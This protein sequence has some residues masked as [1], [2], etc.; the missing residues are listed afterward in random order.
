MKEKVVSRIRRHSFALLVMLL[1]M[2]MVPGTVSATI[3]GSHAF[4]WW[5][6][7][8][9]VQVTTSLTPPVPGASTLLLGLEEWHLDQAQTTQWY[10][11][12]AIS[13]LPTNPFNGAN[14]TA[15]TPGSV[16]MPVVGAEAFI[17]RISNL[18]YAS[19]DNFSFSVGGGVNGISGININDTWNALQTAL[20]VAGSQ[21]MFNL[22]WLD[23][24]P[25]D[26]GGVE[27]WDFNAFA[28]PGNFEW[29]ITPFQGQTPG[30]GRFGIVPNFA[31]A[32][33][34]GFAM[35]GMWYDAVNDGWVHSWESSVPTQ[36]NI[37]D[38]IGGF[39]GPRP[40]PEPSTMLLLGAGLAA[41][42]ILRRKFKN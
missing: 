4:A 5:D 26:A 40:I 30:Q 29:D 33:V 16:I 2:A 20:P 12:I 23:L 18:G 21:F 41:V 10:N 3:L 13:G 14:I 25:G 24:T 27:D 17:Y 15:M 34:F 1:T 39:S 9:G 37:A 22:G 31:N 35:P 38:A 19:G 36:V 7:P 8:G 11:G 42:G 32:A 28:G 6:T